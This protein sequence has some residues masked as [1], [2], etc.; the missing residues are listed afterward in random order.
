MSSF[1][2][3]DRHIFTVAKFCIVSTPSGSTSPNVNELAN[4]LKAINIDSVNYRYDEKTRKTKCSSKEFNEINPQS[5]LNKYGMLRLIQCWAYQSCENDS[6]LDYIIMKAYLFSF[7]TTH[8]VEEAAKNN[9]LA[10][11]L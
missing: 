6:S 2:L 8:D 11:S 9:S 3:T 4:R 1:I 5:L 7:F 10:W